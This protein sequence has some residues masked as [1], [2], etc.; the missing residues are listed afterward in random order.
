MR[1]GLT[2]LI[3]AFSW[4][5]FAFHA[6]T[7]LSAETQ[8]ET[9]HFYTVVI[10]TFKSLGNAVRV[11]D[12]V[13]PRLGEDDRAY[14]RIDRISERFSVRVG[15]FDEKER[16]EA[17][18]AR[19]KGFLPNARIMLSPFE[20]S[21]HVRRYGRGAS[22]SSAESPSPAKTTTPPAADK[23][24]PPPKAREQTDPQMP[25][26][27]QKEVSRPSA[28]LMP[29]HGQTVT[30]KGMV[31]AVIAAV[32]PV[33]SASLN[34]LPDR[35][36]YRVVIKVIEADDIPGHPHILKERI[37]QDVTCFSLVEIRPD[38]VGMK[39]RGLVEYR[40]DERSRLFWISGVERAESGPA[41]Q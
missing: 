2:S 3:I 23:T 31:K 11:Y 18:L 36:L 6:A 34:I 8:P 26:Q 24:T 10:S 15:R 29:A 19:T 32:N 25:S 20:E 9:K 35:T 21:L 13:L 22:Q 7:P 12:R 39:I 14:L 30:G 38:S 5:A 33:S 41:S 1:T 4:I 37:G 16:A 17:F 28:G 27:K 40:G